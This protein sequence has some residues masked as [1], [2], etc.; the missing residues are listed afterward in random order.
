MALRS[1]P[2]ARQMRLAVELRRLR[3]SAGL[4][5]REAATLLGVSPP[6]IS[7]IEASRV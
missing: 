7:Q 1:E 6:Q 5:A 3:D 4:S 2:T